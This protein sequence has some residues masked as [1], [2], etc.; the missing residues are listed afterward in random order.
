M[1][2]WLLQV[3]THTHTPLLAHALAV[4][5]SY[6]LWTTLTSSLLTGDLPSISA[7]SK[8][9]TIT[10]YCLKW[11]GSFSSS[12]EWSANSLLYS[13]KD[14]CNPVSEFSSHSKTCHAEARQTQLLVIPKHTLLSSPQRLT[15][16][17]ISWT[18]HYHQLISEPLLC[19]PRTPCSSSFWQQLSHWSL[20]VSLC[21]FTMGLEGTRCPTHL[22]SLLRCFPNF[23]FTFPKVWT[24]CQIHLPTVLLVT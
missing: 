8:T 16:R 19:K 11:F 24:L 13:A 2:F 10:F 17:S 6:L 3:H 1:S 14:L 7:S 4:A 5:S 23:L 9:L 15:L 12:S 22:D 21:R 20:Q 18:S